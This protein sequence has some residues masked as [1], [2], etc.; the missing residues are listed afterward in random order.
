MDVKTP[1]YVLFL[2]PDAIVW[3][4]T[5]QT[6]TDAPWLRWITPP[7][8]FALQN[9]RR[10]QHDPRDPVAGAV[11]CVIELLITIRPKIYY[12]PNKWWGKKLVLKRHAQKIG[13]ERHYKPQQPKKLKHHPHYHV[14]I[15]DVILTLIFAEIMDQFGE[16]FPAKNT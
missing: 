4:F 14:S 10:K 16:G 13:I 9:S 6:K 1:S 11:C 5:K 15:D 8:V 7:K 3:N 2:T 12:Y